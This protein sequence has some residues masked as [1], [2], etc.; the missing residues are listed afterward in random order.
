MGSN[1]RRCEH[2]SMKSLL[3]TRESEKMGSA[4][5][6]SKVSTDICCNIDMHVGENMAVLQFARQGS[7]LGAG[8]DESTQSVSTSLP[9]H[10]EV[11]ENCCR[12]GRERRDSIRAFDSVVSS[13]A[14]VVLAKDTTKTDS[15]SYLFLL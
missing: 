14:D 12:S 3:R 8:G 1:I 6:P 7:E 4:R 9:S 10:P 5:K 2:G 13:E 11:S 15:I